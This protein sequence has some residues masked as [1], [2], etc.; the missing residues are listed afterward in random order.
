VERKGDLEGLLEKI[1][2]EENAEEALRSVERNGGVPGVDGM[3]TEQL[4]GHLEKNWPT[5]RAKLLD[6]TYVPAPVKRVE[7]PKANGGTRPLGIPTVLDR[8]IQQLMLGELQPLYEPTFSDNSYGFRPERS[9][10]DAVKAAKASMVTEGKSWVVDMDIKGFFDHVDHNILMNQLRKNV[11]DKRV[12]KLIGSYLV[13]GVWKEGKVERPQG[14][15]TPQGGPL[16]PLLANIYLDDLDKELEK[17]GL[18]FSR[19]ADDCNIYVKSRR[20]AERVLEKVTQWIEKNLKL[21]ISAEKSGA[22]RPWKR[23]F[24]GFR[25]SPEGLIEVSEQSLKRFK[26]KV[27]EHWN[28]RRGKSSEQLRDDWKRYVVGWV[29]YYRLTENVR[30][31]ERLDPWIRRHMRKCFWERWHKKKGREKALRR[32]GL[33]GRQLEVAGSSRGAWRLARSW[34]MHKALGNKVLKKFGF[35][36]LA[37]LLD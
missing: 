29:G 33:R 26:E 8:F 12:L 3:T 18:S 13:A 4:R 23:K 20:A 16:S 10:H 14:K 7:I 17:R 34:T 22:D 37:D 5:I 9:A 19:Y 35:L 36:C 2:S 28:A 15:G 24:L 32:L 27:R 25:I 21:E 31:L 30:P 6:G 1:V 11:G